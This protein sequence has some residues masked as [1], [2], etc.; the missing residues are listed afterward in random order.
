MPG[1]AKL[2]KFPVVTVSLNPPSPSTCTVTGVEAGTPWTI[3]STSYVV[4]ATA[5]TPVP[6]R[7]PARTASRTVS[8]ARTSAIAADI[9]GLGA[10]GAVSAGYRF[11]N[12]SQVNSGGGSRGA[13]TGRG[14]PQWG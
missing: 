9:F 14:V 1:T 12:A 5:A 10:R 13:T 8:P 3:P 11:G 7:L 4:G 6:P 2:S